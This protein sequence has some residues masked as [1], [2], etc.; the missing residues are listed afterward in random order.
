VLLRRRLDTA[1]KEQ[2]SQREAFEGFTLQ[3]GERVPAWKRMVEEFEADASKK[4][5]Y[6]MK[7]VGM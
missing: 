5:P 3:Q 6:E 2:K 4:N 7:I 1:R